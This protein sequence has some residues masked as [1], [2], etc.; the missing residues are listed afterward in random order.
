ME[1]LHMIDAIYQGANFSF[2]FWSQCCI[3]YGTQSA[4]TALLQPSIHIMDTIALFTEVGHFN[5][6]V[7]LSIS[8][9]IDY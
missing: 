1:I 7:V 3:Q 9:G 6:G 8:W 2:S 5:C 4:T